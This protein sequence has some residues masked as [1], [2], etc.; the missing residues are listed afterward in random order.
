MV[1]EGVVGLIVGEGAGEETEMVTDSAAVVGVAMI[2]EAE[3]GVVT[4][5]AMVEIEAVADTGE[6]Q[7][8]Y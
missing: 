5:E 3:I 6:I 1:E 8:L 7:G 4:G 2:T